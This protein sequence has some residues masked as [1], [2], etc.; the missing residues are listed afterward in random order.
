MCQP[1]IIAFIFAVLAGIPQAQACMNSPTYTFLSP[2]IGKVIR[3]TG[4]NIKVQDG[5]RYELLKDLVQKTDN[6][7][8]IGVIRVTGAARVGRVDETTGELHPYT[9]IFKVFSDLSIT[10]C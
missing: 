4:Q 2:Q 9:Y 1:L 6:G 8:T 3:M 5:V 10:R 7:Q